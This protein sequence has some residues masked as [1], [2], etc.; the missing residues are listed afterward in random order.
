MLNL[1]FTLAVL[2]A[3]QANS[4]S[5][6]I[7]P[8]LGLKVDGKSQIVTAK[9]RDYRICCADCEK[10]LKSNPDTY[11]DKNGNPKNAAKAMGSMEHEG[12]KH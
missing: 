1:V 11:L 12:H 2:A 7:C 8:V 5:N 4:A 9:G 6:T 3:P 10:N